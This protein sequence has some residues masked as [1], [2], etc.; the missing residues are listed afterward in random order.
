MLVRCFTNRVLTLTAILIALAPFYNGCTHASSNGHIVARAGRNQ[1]TMDEVAK[2]VDTTSAY[3]VRNFVTRWVDEQL[4]YQKAVREGVENSPD[5][6]SSVSNYSRQLAIALYLQK[7][8]YSTPSK[9]TSE[10]IASF[11]SAH[12]E[13]FRA[14]DK[15]LLVNMASFD[16][17]STAVAFRNAILSTGS[18]AS[19]FSLL[20][21]YSILSKN[22]SIFINENNS[23]SEIWR[24]VESLPVGRPSFPIQVDS[25]SFVIQVLKKI[26]AGDQLPISYVKP[27]I[28]ERLTIEHRK[29]EYVKILDSLKSAGD[30]SIDPSIAI[31]DTNDKE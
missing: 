9:V 14:S 13:E 23:N 6:R 24:V 3:A 7:R 28:R 29:Q 19:A 27:L 15:L 16:K 30:F 2:H 17:R 8:I 1:L 18:W 20:P 11:Y 31:K 25:V 10:Q 5:Y 12:K 21:Q 22:D 26:M 4:L